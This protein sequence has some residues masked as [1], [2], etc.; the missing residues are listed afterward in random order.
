MCHNLSVAINVGNETKEPDVGSRAI[1]R[2]ER[3][4]PLGT[5]RE[6]MW[7]EDSHEQRTSHSDPPCTAVAWRNPQDFWNWWVVFVRCPFLRARSRPFIDLLRNAAQACP[8][9]SHFGCITKQSTRGDGPSDFG[10]FACFPCGIA[11]V[12]VWRNSHFVRGF[13]SWLTFAVR[14]KVF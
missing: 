13:W 9:S 12:C 5:C 8:Q 2:N 1:K 3:L 14:W 4:A 6:K 11:A 10:I 7:S